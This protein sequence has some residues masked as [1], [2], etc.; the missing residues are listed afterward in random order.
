MKSPATD[1]VALVGLCAHVEGVAVR[2]FGKFWETQMAR[3]LIA[4][5][6][7]VLNR[8]EDVIVKVHGQDVRAV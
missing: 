3:A 5:T 8:R 2:H 1:R 6:S 7:S 4:L